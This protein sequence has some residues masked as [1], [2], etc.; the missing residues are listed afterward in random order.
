LLEKLEALTRQGSGVSNDA[1][2]DLV[3][4]LLTA[5]GADMSPEQHSVC[6]DLLDAIMA[7]ASVSA[8]STACARLA[9]LP[10][11]PSSL[12]ATWADGPIEV[13]APILQHA[14]NLTS[15][16]LIRTLSQAGPGHLRAV[17]KRETLAEDVT[18]FIARRGDREAT[19]L[20]LLNRRA[21]FSEAS[22]HKL[23]EAAIGD[24]MLRGAIAHRP[25]LPDA[26]VERVWPLLDVELKA[27]LIASG[28]RYSMAEIDEACRETS[29]ALVGAVRAGALP[30]SIGTYRAMVVDGPAT[31]SEALAEIVETGRLVEA[32]HLIARTLALSDGVAINLFFGV[33]DRGAAVLAR[34]ADLEE[35]VVHHIA[36]ARARLAW[37][38]STDPRRTAA[39][40]RAFDKAQA[41]EIV[42]ALEALWNSGVANTGS[43]RRFRSAI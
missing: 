15:A 29:A 7:R 24:S 5:R 8:R 13:A 42:S 35:S 43:R 6:G 12:L 34:H 2:L 39:L 10:M 20:T 26:I 4:D 28:W 19:V 18:A 40:L 32:A 17:A 11:A 22:L 14:P 21:K 30:Q 3:V 41:R 23:S 9:R 25:D 37:V 31:L 33:Y 16:D 38:R 1:V 27:R 36:S